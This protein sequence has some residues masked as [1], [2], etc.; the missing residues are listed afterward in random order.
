L[1]CRWPGTALR[2]A[3]G[4]VRKQCLGKV[5]DVFR[6]ALHHLIFPSALR[7]SIPAG[8]LGKAI[9]NDG[10]EMARPTTSAITSRA[11]FRSKCS[12]LMCW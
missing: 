11:N 6:D 3:L 4:I 10:K 9:A 5:L 1:S 8:V 2:P 7:R 12:L